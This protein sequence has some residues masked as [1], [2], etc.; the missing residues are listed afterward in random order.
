MIRDTLQVHKEGSWTIVL[1]PVLDK[2]HKQMKHS[3]TRMTPNEAQ[4]D[5]HHIQVKSNSVLKEK[6]LQYFLISKKAIL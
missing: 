5:E 2:Y 6:Y 3:T 1:K 4:K